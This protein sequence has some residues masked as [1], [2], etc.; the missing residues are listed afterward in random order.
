LAP[1]PIVIRTEAWNT[2]A[3]AGSTWSPMPV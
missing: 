3:A 1:L 2:A